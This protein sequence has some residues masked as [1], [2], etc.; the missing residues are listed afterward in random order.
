M[1]FQSFASERFW[2]LYS[3]LPVE[4][5]RLAD[6]HTE[7]FRQDPFHPSLHLKQV[8]EA[9]TVRIGRSYRYRLPRGRHFPLGLDGLARSL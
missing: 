4:V 2:Q 7:L 5:Q 9:C 1:P 6:K 8:G 3:D